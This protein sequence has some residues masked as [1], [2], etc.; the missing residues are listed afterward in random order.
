[1]AVSDL[2]VENFPDVMDPKF[3]ARL[4]EDLDRIADGQVPWLDIMR[5]FYGP[6][7]QELAAAKGR[8]DRVKTLPTGLACPKCGQELWIRWGKAGEF[9]GCSAHPA[10]DFTSDIERDAQGDIVPPVLSPPGAK[11]VPRALPARSAARSWW[12]AGGETG[13]FWGAPAIP[14]AASPGISSGDRTANRSF[15]RQPQPRAISPVPN[16][17]V[18]GPW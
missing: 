4:E 15:P 8:M 18:R 17:I 11:P 9:L 10:C 5:E 13:S 1:M 14:S 12:C 7:A 6:F 3:T 2:L 16:R